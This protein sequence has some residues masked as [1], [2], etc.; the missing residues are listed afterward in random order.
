MRPPACGTIVLVMTETL[1]DPLPPPP[2]PPA[3]AAR[4]LVRHPDDKAIGGVCAAFGRFTDTDPVLWRVL[5][6]AL[7]LFGGAGLVIYALAWLLI[8]RVD[9]PQSFVERHLRNADQSVSVAGVILLFLV[10]LVLFAA[11]DDGSGVVVLAVVVA[12]A[13]LVA[14]ERRTAEPGTGPGATAWQPASEPSSYG[15]PPVAQPFAPPV[16]A[17]PRAPKA[18]S[19]LGPVTLSAAALVTGLLLL[20]RELGTTGITGPRVL[21]AAMLVVGVGLLVGTWYG[22]ARWLLA[23][24]L[25][26]GLVLVPVAAFSGT[27]GPFRAGVGERTWIPTGDDRRT[28]FELG[29]G[30]ATLDLRQ[31]SPA[32]SDGAPM[33]RSLRA[34]VGLGSLVV[35]V[36]QDLTVSITSSV[37]L[38][39]LVVLDTDGR[40][41]AVASE[42]PRGISTTRSYG[43]PGD[44]QLELELVV[45]AGEIE[46]RRVQG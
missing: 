38:G 24:G 28:V 12:L 8:P 19:I 3:P 41:T 40:R 9:Q 44:R 46:V 4:R 22:R 32:M 23:V 2:S 43:P 18:R 26:L 7:V 10:A 14:R 45:G 37:R 30:E 25:A 35:L 36:P 11:I 16:A 27:P 42:N 1:Q 39:E 34:E 21:A 33:P 13:Y 15:V 29:A 6:A 5:F 17:E 31:L 20:L